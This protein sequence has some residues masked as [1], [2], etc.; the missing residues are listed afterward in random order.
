MTKGTYFMTGYKN[1][2]FVFFIICAETLFASQQPKTPSESLVNI[3]DV[4]TTSQQNTVK[5]L[6]VFD[7]EV[8]S[9]PNNESM[10]LFGTHYLQQLNNWLYFGF[11]VHAPLV[12]GKYGGFMTFDATVHAQQK[13]YGDL[14]INGGS[15]FG[16]GGGGASTEQSKK[17][18]GT[19]G[20]IKS[21]IGLGYELNKN[22]S[23]GVNYTYFKFINSQIDSS[24]LNFFIQTPVSYLTNPYANSGKTVK[25][26]NNFFKSDE[27]ILTLEMNNIFQINPIG[28]NKNTINSVALQF[29][30]FLD[31]N[32]Y[33]FLEVEVGYKG[34]PL[35][36]Q[37]IH[38]VGHKFLLSPRV[39][40]YTQA[41]VGSGGYSPKDIDTG[42]GLLIYPKFSLEYL[43][44]KDLGVSLSSGYLVAPTGTSKNYTFGTAINYHISQKYK[45][46]NGFNIVDDSKYKGVRFS[47]FNQTEFDAKIDGQAHHNINLISTQI[48][49]LLG[50]NWYFP[51]QGSIAYNDFKEYPGYGELLAGIGIQNK[52]TKA[53]DFQN[54]F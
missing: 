38:G 35:Y 41:G 39:N 11:G 10:D 40:L 30:H 7:Y 3:T 26:T 47:L 43:F 22:V 36:N 51:I 33:L 9:L 37:I 52:Y 13:V 20:F 8:I 12:K 49:N 45:N 28:T 23:L 18:S 16:G 1:Y 21:Y 48:D 42:A 15:S 46:T 17:L 31:D 24:Q 25:S 27:N 14:F 50:D 29:S 32:N 44:N 53:D 19:G 34:R 4:N 5:G 2:L 54:F 6:I